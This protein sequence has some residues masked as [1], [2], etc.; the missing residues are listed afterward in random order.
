M[1]DVELLLRDLAGALDLPEP[2]DLRAGV[3]ARIAARRRRRRALVLAFAALLV[4][5]AAV[6]AVPEARARL[7]DWLGVGSTKVVFVDRLPVVAPRGELR[8]GQRVSTA[9]AERRLG[10]RLPRLP[11]SDAGPPD[12]TWVDASGGAVRVTQVWGGGDRP[13]LLLQSTR[14]ATAEW[15][16]QKL[17]G[18]GTTVRS[19][20]LNGHPALALLGAPHFVLYLDGRTGQ[21]V[22]ADVV[23][24]GDV[25]LW[26]LGDLTLRLEGDL[27][28]DE[29]LR[30]ARATR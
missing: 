5:A 8:L 17:V 23:L 20:T 29:M 11:A 16:S 26:Q 3:A 4:A 10:G 21:P 12:A 22:T 9:E 7:L 18:S 6:L 30:L 2:P 24:A 27:T 13:R 15:L 28:Y 19:T 1:T 14:G 25:F